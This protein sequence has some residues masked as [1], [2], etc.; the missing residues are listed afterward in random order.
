MM[1]VESAAYLFMIVWCDGI[2]TAAELKRNNVILFFLGQ[3]QLNR[4][5]GVRVTH[6]RLE[7]TCGTE[8]SSD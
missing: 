7:D 4:A 3:D 6:I 2:M 8:K 5:T 1:L